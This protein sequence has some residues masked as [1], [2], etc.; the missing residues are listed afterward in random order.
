MQ[1]LGQGEKYRLI[2]E[3]QIQHKVREMNRLKTANDP[4]PAKS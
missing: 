4:L 1:E 2:I 3:Q